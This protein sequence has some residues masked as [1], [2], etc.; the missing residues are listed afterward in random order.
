[1]RKCKSTL[2]FNHE[3]LGWSVNLVQ[4]RSGTGLG[5]SVNLFL[6]DSVRQQGDQQHS[7]D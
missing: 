5:W 3:I 1:M 2:D 6:L 7:S 4:Y